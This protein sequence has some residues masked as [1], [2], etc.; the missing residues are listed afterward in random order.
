MKKENNSF[1]FFLNASRS[2]FKRT[3]VLFKRVFFFTLHFILIFSSIDSFRF[4]LF[5]KFIDRG[6]AELTLFI[7]SHTDFFIA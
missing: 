4:T 1:F 3:H 2:L 6:F 5:Q 7:K